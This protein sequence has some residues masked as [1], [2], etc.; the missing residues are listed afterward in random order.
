MEPFNNAANVVGEVFR[1]IPVFWLYNAVGGGNRPMVL[2]IVLEVL[3]LQFDGSQ[4]SICGICV[5]TVPR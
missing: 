4:H 1:P 5:N 3:W 2:L